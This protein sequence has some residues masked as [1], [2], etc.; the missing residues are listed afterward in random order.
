MNL[1]SFIKNSTEGG[2]KVLPILYKSKKPFLKDWPK[3]SSNESIQVNKWFK[4][5]ET[6]AGIPTGEINN[7][8]VVDIDKKNDGF[9]S[10]KKL[11]NIIGPIEKESNYI[12]STG[13]GGLHLYY[14]LRKDEKIPSYTGIIDGIDI[15]GEGG[16]VVSPFSTHENGNIYLPKIDHEDTTLYPDQLNYAP[17]KLINFILN[18]K[19]K[20]QISPIPTYRHITNDVKNKIGERNTGLFKRLCQLRNSPVSYNGF[21]AMAHAENS[22]ICEPPLDNLEVTQMAKNVF[23]RYEPSEMKDEPTI[24]EEAFYGVIGKIVNLIKDET[25]AS[26]ESLLFQALAILG[27]L[28]DRKFYITINGSNI[29]TN[30]FVLIV[31]KTSKARKGTSFRAVSYFFKKAWGKVYEDRIRRGVSTGEGIIWTIRDDVYID[32]IKK[33]GE[34]KRKLQSPG[35]LDKN[36]IFL[37]EEFSKPIKNARRESNNLSETLR[38]AFDSETLQS[39]SKTQ[40]AT[41]TDPNI[42]LI[43]H[44]TREEFTRVLNEVDKDNGF[45]NR[46]LFVHSYRSNII[47]QPKDFEELLIKSDLLTEL[48]LLKDF[49]NKSHSTKVTFSEDGAFWWN[50]FYE[51]YALAPEQANENIKGRTETHILKVA[52]ILAVSDRTHIIN[53]NHLESAKAMLD[54]STQTIDYI[55]KDSKSNSNSAFA[56]LEFLKS[57]GGKCSRTEIS[58]ELFKK[59]V[60]SFKID[61]YRDELRENCLIEISFQDKT[62]I[63][64]L[65]CDTEI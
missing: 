54:Y 58:Y 61:Q 5:K 31:G 59:K 10:L 25:E 57:K 12:V 32:F 4:G 24:S 42:T 2:L 7:L 39:I 41:A 38:V 43:G 17:E 45:F 23:N 20:K 27:N 49:I 28:L 65:L 33:N 56:I 47:S 21:L 60:R 19:M 37:E 46:I 8:F 13:G 1:Y 15:R 36:I 40:P 63:W 55:F 51:Q 6:N 22:L 30:E 26:S 3:N 53:A 44:T 34:R 52:M 14:K 11:E 18:H 35:V 16:Q 64:S 50:N 9:E 29:Y 62:E 48:F